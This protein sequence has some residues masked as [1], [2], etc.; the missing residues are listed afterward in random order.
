M[1]L[2]DG[3]KVS[4]EIYESLKIEVEKLKAIGAKIPHL[5]AVLVGNNPASQTYVNAKVKACEQVGFG[6]TLVKLDDNISEEN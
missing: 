3:R 1:Q 6:T 4:E 5:A 2:I